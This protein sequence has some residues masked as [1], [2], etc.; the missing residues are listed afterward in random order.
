MRISHGAKHQS[1]LI[2][3][4]GPLKDELVWCLRTER[5]LRVQRGGS[6][7]KAWGARGAGDTVQ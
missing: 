1:L 2:E 4:H 5:W 6:R 7:Q 3:G